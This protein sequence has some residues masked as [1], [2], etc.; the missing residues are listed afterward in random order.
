MKLYL[1]H[2]L[3]S[4]KEIREIELKVEAETGIKL[5]N[6]FYDCGRTDIVEIDAGKKTRFDE[7]LD[8]VGIVNNDIYQVYDSD[9]I[10]AFIGDTPSIG[11]TCE[12]WFALSIGRPIY[13]VSEKFTMHPWVRYMVTVSKGKAFKTWEEFAEYFKGE[14]CQN[15]MIDVPAEVDENIKNVV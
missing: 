1:A 6:P 11:T 14:I 7:N 15:E 12:L 4:R 2:P 13:V 10:V 5:M 8:F 3:D 9:G